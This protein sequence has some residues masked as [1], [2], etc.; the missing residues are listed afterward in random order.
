MDTK[1]TATAFQ[2][3]EADGFKSHQFQSENVYFFS[4]QNILKLSLSLLKLSSLQK[5][6]KAY[7]KIFNLSRKEKREL[8]GMKISKVHS[9]L[10]DIASLRNELIYIK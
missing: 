9:C 3:R 1:L 10:I 5:Q 2:V 7:F 6:K 4:F 8:F